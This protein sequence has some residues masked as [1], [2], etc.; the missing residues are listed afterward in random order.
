MAFDE[1][2]QRMVDTQIAARGVRDRRVLGAMRIVPR[3]AFVPED[4]ADAAYADKA[5]PIGAG[6]TISQPYIVALMAEALSLA[7]TDRVLE[8]GGGSGYAA[9]VMSLLAGEVFVIELHPALAEAAEARLAELG[10]RNVHVTCGDGTKGWPEHAPFDAISVAAGGETEP[11][12]LREQLAVGGR[13]VIPVGRD[14]DNQELL[15]LRRTG[16]D[17]WERTSLGRVH[18]VPLVGAE[19]DAR[20]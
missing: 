15:R 10:Y 11:P 6:Q 20:P 2:R 12:A 7:P 13:L 17:E 5:L 3:E 14:A 9:A 1:Q 16:E 18:F 4:L 8:V 19:A